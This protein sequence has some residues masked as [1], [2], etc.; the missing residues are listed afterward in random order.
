MRSIETIS[1]LDFR[2]SLVKGIVSP[3]FLI[4]GNYFNV[5]HLHELFIYDDTYI[6][7][8]TFAQG[9]EFAH[10]LIAHSLIRSFTHFV[11]QISDCE[12]FAQIAQDK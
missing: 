6:L 10:S 11:Y 12:R 9:W 2:Q 7:L 1:H 8:D 5:K 4:S 3:V